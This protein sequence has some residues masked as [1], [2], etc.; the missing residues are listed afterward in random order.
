[1]NK[2]LLYTI[3]ASILLVSAVGGA[4]MFLINSQPS[5][6]ELPRK[7]QTPMVFG[8]E[9]EILSEDTFENAFNLLI[10]GSDTREGQRYNDGVEGE[11][12]DVT[13]ML[14]VDETHQRADVVSFPRDTIIPMGICTG[15]DPAGDMQQINTG[16]MLGGADCVKQSV[17]SLTGQ[18][19][20]ATV[21]VDFNAV[22][23]LTVAVGGVPVCIA[24]P[25][26]SYHTGELIFSEGEHT[27]S[28]PEALSF[29]RERY[30][31]G[32]GG[33]LGRVYNQQIFIQAFMK[34]FR[35]TDFMKE[36]K[37]FW[38]LTDV[39]ISSLELSPGLNNPKDLLK[40]ANTFLSVP[41]SNYQ[42]Y[43]APVYPNPDDPNRLLI[44]SEQLS[45]L[46]TYINTPPMLVEAVD[47]ETEIP[48]TTVAKSNEV[49]IPLKPETLP[50]GDLYAPRTGE[51]YTVTV[52]G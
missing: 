18:T 5:K 48:E 9:I 12:N 24:E 39:V 38:D 44:N 17:E 33:D 42:F 21:L 32:D 35:A 23:D 28:G 1:M 14:M 34:E 10:I 40:M 2:K 37:K 30:G 31:F 51:S 52:C 13:M 6:E 8:E 25:I 11:L 22:E 41:E 16:L 46:F 27:L 7:A 29:V 43:T 49:V 4:L 47:A 36:P 26:Y 45:E 20:S 3:G 15:G 50:S 19:V